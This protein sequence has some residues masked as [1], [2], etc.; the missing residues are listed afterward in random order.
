MPFTCTSTPSI[1]DQLCLV[2]SLEII[3]EIGGSSLDFARGRTDVVREHNM[4]RFKGGSPTH[5][6]YSQHEYGEA[7]LYQALP[8]VGGRPISYSAKGSH[9][10]YAFAGK[11]D[12]HDGSEFPMLL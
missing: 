5:V 1:K 4:I 10:N 9:A 11:H 2:M 7:F 3:W 12:L 8:K 6:W